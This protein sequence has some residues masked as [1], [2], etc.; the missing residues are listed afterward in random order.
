MTDLLARLAER[1]LA[2]TPAL[3]PVPPPRFAPGPTELEETEELVAPS[4]GRVDERRR[5]RASADELTDEPP[6]ARHRAPVGREAQPSGAPPSGKARAAGDVPP[7]EATREESVPSPDA[8]PPTGE[9]AARRAPD[10]HVSRLPTRTRRPTPELPEVRSAAWTAPAATPP[11]Q[12]AARRPEAWDDPPLV[13]RP[14]VPEPSPVGPSFAEE[15]DD[16]ARRRAEPREETTVHVSIGRIEV[17]GGEQ[18]EPTPRPVPWTEGPL[19][20]LGDYLQ[21]RRGGTS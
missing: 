9:R 21:R 17:R 4:P 1:T 8:P 13:E 5:L 15:G 3:R 11:K 18:P 7:A 2:T 6:A 10:A 14:E 12:P 16:G 20:S 19:I